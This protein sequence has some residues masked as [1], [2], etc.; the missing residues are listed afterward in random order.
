MGGQ[1][2]LEMASGRGCGLT[3]GSDAHKSGRVGENFEAAVEL[4]KRSGVT[5]YRRFAGGQ[6][7]YVPF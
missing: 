4:A 5:K 3:F 7:E 2:M 1:R 6:Y